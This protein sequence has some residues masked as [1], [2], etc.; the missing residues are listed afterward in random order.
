MFPLQVL[1][2]MLAVVCFF[3]LFKKAFLKSFSVKPEAETLQLLLPGCKSGYGGRDAASPQ[4]QG[5]KNDSKTEN[6]KI[7]KSEKHI[8]N[9]R[10][11]EYKIANNS[12]YMM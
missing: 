6:K 7:E 12:V 5:I 10:A 9:T 8:D 3:N 11:M 2:N 1:V 4:Q